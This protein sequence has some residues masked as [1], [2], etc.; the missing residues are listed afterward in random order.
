MERKIDVVKI[1]KDYLPKS[2]DKAVSELK[3]AMKGK[4][5]EIE[6]TKVCLTIWENVTE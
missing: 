2:A 4:N 1:R 6:E 3:A 5:I